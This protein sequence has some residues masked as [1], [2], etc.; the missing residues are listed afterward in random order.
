MI[1]KML[2]SSLIFFAGAGWSHADECVPPPS[3]ITG[4]LRVV[5]TKHANGSLIRAFVVF[6]DEGRCVS[7][8]NDDG[9][10][11]NVTIRDVHL[12]PKDENV[13]G[14]NE[15][16]GRDVK[17]DGNMTLP[18]T[19]WHVGSTMMLDASIEIVPDDE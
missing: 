9:E 8:E 17:A 10:R 14:W 4:Q 5:E 1:S 13:A 11:S 15:A 18:F 6:V 2:L 7:L 19:A 3:E 12:A 16:I